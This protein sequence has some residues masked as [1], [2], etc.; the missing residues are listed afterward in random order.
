MLEASGAANGWNVVLWGPMLCGSLDLIENLLH[1]HAV[2]H[3]RDHGTVPSS[4]PV[5]SGCAVLKFMC[6]LGGAVPTA[7]LA[8]AGLT[9]RCAS[10]V[11][12]DPAVQDKRRL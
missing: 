1:D 10:L 2:H 4:A 9:R 6:L 7:A 5:G 11:R 8:L 12:A 3:Y